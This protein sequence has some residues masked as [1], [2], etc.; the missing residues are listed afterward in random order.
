MRSGLRRKNPQGAIAAF[1]AAFPGGSEPAALLLR[2]VDPEF[3]PAAWKSLCDEAG[4]DPR[5]R[6]LGTRECGIAE[7]YAALDT[8]LSLHRSE[9]YGLTLAEALAAG[10]PVVGTSW[11]LPN[12]IVGHPLFRAVPS[13]LVPV[14]DPGGPYAEFGSLNWAEPDTEATA[15]HLRELADRAAAGGPA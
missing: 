4:A 7:F 8:L 13:T 10:I 9:G 5:I 15:R 3:R 11:S 12:E 2:C 14:R 6:P 1:R